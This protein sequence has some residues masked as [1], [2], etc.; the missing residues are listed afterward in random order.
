MPLLMSIKKKLL[1]WI[2]IQL[3]GR[4]GSG[5][6]PGSFSYDVVYYLL[7]GLLKICLGEVHY[8]I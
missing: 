6:Q 8:L 7:L 3:F 1:R 5:G 4:L 2:T